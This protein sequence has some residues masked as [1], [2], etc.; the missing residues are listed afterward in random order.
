MKRKILFLI[1]LVAS[2]HVVGSWILAAGAALW[3]QKFAGATQGALLEKVATAPF[4]PIHYLAMGRLLQG[5]SLREPFGGIIVGTWVA[6]LL[7]VVAICFV[8]FRL[9]RRDTPRGSKKRGFEAVA[10]TEP[11]S[12]L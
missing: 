5:F 4:F 1:G 3:V 6:W 12:G 2:I 10:A 11:P 9:Y 8:G 7:T